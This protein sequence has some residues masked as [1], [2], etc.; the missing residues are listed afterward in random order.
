M[1]RSTWAISPLTRIPIAVALAFAAW[2]L[3]GLFHGSLG[4]PA[5]LAAL[6]VCVFDIMAVIFGQLALA[7]AERGDSPMPW[8]AALCVFVG[9]AAYAQWEHGRLS[10]WPIAGS[11]LMATVPVA[12]LLAVEGQ[13]RVRARDRGR[14]AGRIEPPVP[15]YSLR[16]WI[17][18][19]GITWAAVRVATRDPGLA[20]GDAWLIASRRA[21]AK[22]PAPVAARSA[23]FVQAYPELTADGQVTEVG[24]DTADNRPDTADGRA[25]TATVRA[26]TSADSGRRVPTVA[27]LVRQ[28][29]AELGD[30]TDSVVAAVRDVLPTA[31]DVAIE[32]AMQRQRQATG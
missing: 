28:A 18:Y 15:S 1:N 14:E 26:L 16:K 25:D 2:G 12:A 22:P 23:R 19:P 8:N 21:E 11:I 13:L 17:F 32:R 24:A 29:M 4:M 30:D 7:V 6:G 5:W 10:G 20:P 9:L 31:S 3:F 27:S